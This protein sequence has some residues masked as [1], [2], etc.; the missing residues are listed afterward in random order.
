MSYIIYFILLFF[1]L[2]VLKTIIKSW[3]CTIPAFNNFLTYNSINAVEFGDNIVT[4]N[5]QKATKIDDCLF[6]SVSLRCCET[7][8]IHSFIHYMAPQSGFGQDMSEKILPFYCISS[9]V[10]P[11]TG[12]KGPAITVHAIR[13]PE[14]R[15]FLVSSAFRHLLPCVQRS[16]IYCS[17]RH[18]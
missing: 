5:R 14:F 1:E 10:L 12:H 17:S 9:T 8:F 13:P 16:A 6:Y 3:F 4:F 15:S 18:R 11:V 2:V 7:R